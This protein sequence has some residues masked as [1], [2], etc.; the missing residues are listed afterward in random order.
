MMSLSMLFR[1]AW[2]WGLSSDPSLTVI[3][4]AMTAR[5]TPQ[6]RPRALLEGTNT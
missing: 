4:A 1:R 6:A 2:I 3:D 5:D